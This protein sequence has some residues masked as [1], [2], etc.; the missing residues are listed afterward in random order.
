MICMA[1]KK[2][3]KEIRLSERDKKLLLD[4]ATVY[5]NGRAIDESEYLRYLIDNGHLLLDQK[6]PFMV[7]DLD[8]RQLINEVNK[9][10]VSINQISKNNNSGNYQEMDKEKLD[11]YMKKIME[12]LTTI[13]QCR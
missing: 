12:L 5:A 9:I 7:Q 10:G 2:Y 3:R 6:K 1:A 4:G 11:Y 13:N 8:M